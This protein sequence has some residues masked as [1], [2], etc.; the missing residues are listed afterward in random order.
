MDSL[1][2]AL[3]ALAAGLAIAVELGWFRRREAVVL[4]AENPKPRP[5][6]KTATPANAFESRPVRGGGRGTEN[7]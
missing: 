6:R 7:R 3:Q 1:L 2:T 4:P 5:K